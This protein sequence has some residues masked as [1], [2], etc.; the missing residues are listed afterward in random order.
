[1]GQDRLSALALISIENK[2]SRSLDCSDLID[3]FASLKVR[4]DICSPLS[5]QHIN[6]ACNNYK[7]LKS[8]RLADYNN[9]KENLSVDILIGANFY[10]KFME[11]SI[12]RGVTGPVA[13]KSKLGYLISG[14][15]MVNRNQ[16]GNST[17]LS[18]HVLKVAS[19]FNRELILIKN[20]LNLLWD[21]SKISESDKI[22]YENFQKNIKFNGAMYEVELPFK[23]DHPVIGDNY[24]L[25]KSRFLALEKK[26][27]SEK[28]LFASYKN[29][30]KDQLSKDIIEKVSNLESNIGGIHYLPH[31]P[32]IRGD[33]LTSKVRLVF[34]TSACTSGPSLN[35]CLFSGPSLTTSLYS[36]LL[37][38]RAKRIALIAD[39]EK[40]FLNIALAEKHRGFVRFICVT[41]FPFLSATL[42]NHAKHYAANDFDFGKELIQSLHVD[43]LNAKGNFY[44]RKFESNSTELNSLIKEDNPTSSEI[45]KVF[46][47]KWD[48]IED[49]FIFS[50]QDLLYLVDNRPTKRRDDILIEW[51]DIINDLGSVPFICIPRWYSKCVGSIQ[52][53]KFELYGFCHASLKAYGCC[54]YLRSSAEEIANSCLVTSKSRVSPLLK[55]TIPELELRAILLLANLFSV[56]YK[57]LSCVLNISCVKLFSDSFICLYWVNNVN[58]KYEAFVQIRLEK[59][60]S[61]SDINFWS[62]I[63]SEKNSAD[64]ISR[65]CK[66]STFQNNDLWFK[67]PSF[68][69]NDFISWPSFD[70]RKQRDSLSVAALISSEH[71]IINLD[72]MNIKNF[73]TYDRLPKVTALVLRFVRIIKKEFINDFYTMTTLELNNAELLR[74]KF[75]QK[76][77]FNSESYNR[78]ERDLGFTVDELIRC[79]GRLSNAPIP[80]DF[81]FPIYLPN[82]SYLSNLIIFHYHY[83][84]KH[85][86]VK[87][88]LNELRTKFWLTKAR[89]LIKTIIRNCYICRRFDSKPYKYPNSPPLPLSRVSDKYALKYVGV[90]LCGPIM[91]K[92]IY[93][94]NMMNKAWIFVATCCSTRF[95]YLDLVPDCTAK[96][97]I[98]GLRRF[99]SRYGAPL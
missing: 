44:L 7:H 71:S 8:L 18:S 58:K 10:W 84:T 98:L 60:R 81:K 65:G 96:A 41:S 28:D 26:L 52:K 23:I 83:V 22:V 80:F 21:D 99:I 94:T 97:C 35:E 75:I 69:F 55:N 9:S 47:L 16:I 14:P 20:N 87:E 93:E 3:E 51:N 73:K 66:F 77:I 46:G 88:T 56:V 90:D 95:L 89:S 48:K 37:R 92:N 11:N 13:T 33:K 40:A 1:M 4:K 78:L 76:S 2:I 86:G 91:I 85:S 30:I 42:I 43:D 67:G 36:T 61:L 24:N 5:G 82:K 68:L 62:Y 12:I 79:Q 19:D 59:I 39:I 15:T 50:F 38:F 53:I 31:R 63:E 64:I 25:R 74:I 34:D 17:V 70:L 29:I 45:N 32:V 49:N 27:A 6:I 54:I 72:F 57:E